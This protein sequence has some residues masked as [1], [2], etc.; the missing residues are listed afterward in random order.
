M[1]KPIDKNSFESVWQKKFRALS[2]ILLLS[3]ALNIGL[4]TTFA[5]FSIATAKRNPLEKPQAQVCASPTNADTIKAF[6]TASFD[7]LVFELENSTLL[8]DGYRVRDLAL[9]YLVSYHYLNLDHALSGFTYQRRLITFLH[10]EGGEK[11]DLMVYPGLVDV[12]FQNINSYI[13]REKWPFTPEGLFQEILRQRFSID[14]DLKQA[15]YSS[16]EFLT[17]YTLFVRGEPTMSREEILAMM[18]EGDWN[19]LE[20][21]YREQRKNPDLGESE[22]QSLL[23]HYMLKPSRVASHLLVK[24][25]P[26]YALKKISDKDVLQLVKQ[27]SVKNHTVLQFLRQLLVSVRSDDVRLASAKALYKLEGIEPKNP[28]DYKQALADFLPNVISKQTI[29][30][31]SDSHSIARSIQSYEQEGVI[32]HTVKEG[33]SL[34]KIAKF[35]K[36]EIEQIRAINDLGKKD[37]LPLGKKLKIPKKI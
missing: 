37:L 20:Y 34:W 15:F 21:F 19:D 8:E 6:F 32:I 3:G 1:T 16:P 17:M 2:Q 12:H 9:A 36:V 27:L 30:S 13:Q 18:M 33:D 11:F 10:H 26:E 31:E 29:K 24:M 25:E 5:Y 23:H 4:I 28:L 14:P 7:D 35:Y 22:R